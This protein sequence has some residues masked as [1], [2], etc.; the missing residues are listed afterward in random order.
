[1]SIFLF[2]TRLDT[3]AAAEA[4]MVVT[5]ASFRNMHHRKVHESIVSM[6][7]ETSTEY[8]LQ[9]SLLSQD[10][11]ECVQVYIERTLDQRSRFD[12]KPG[13]NILS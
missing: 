13:M 7:F 5:E 4:L 9:L 10:P 3:N 2:R 1:L 12:F 11:Q 8:S 6:G